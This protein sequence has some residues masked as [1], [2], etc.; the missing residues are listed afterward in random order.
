[1]I[2]YSPW[3][4]R[5]IEKSIRSLLMLLALLIT[6]EAHSQKYESIGI[7]NTQTAMPFGKFTGLFKGPLHPGLEYGR[8]FILS[9]KEKHDWFLEVKAGYFFHRFVQHGIPVYANAGYRYKISSRIFAETSIGA[10]GM[11]SIPATGKYKL[12]DNGDYENNKGIGRVQ[13]I[14][15]YGIG[16]S[17]LLTTSTKKPMR[18]FLMYQQKL[19]FPFIRSYVPLL[20]YNS[21]MIGITRPISKTNNRKT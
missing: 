14:A 16:G 5:G 15:T 21:F 6:N 1:M 7:Y 9:S 18:G 10:G 20:P 8:G 2:K 17:Y 11:Q 4:T 3:L 19:Q 13:A 12:N